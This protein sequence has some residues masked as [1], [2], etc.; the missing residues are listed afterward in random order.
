MI[1]IFISYSNQD[2]DFVDRLAYDLKSI[3]TNIFYAKWE[4][5]VG[6]SIVEKINE[7]LLSHDH[8]IIILSSNSVKSNWVKKEL[9][10]SLMRQLEEN[11]IK[12]KPILIEN[13]DMPPLLADIKYADFRNDYNLGFKDLIDSFTEDFNLE[14]FILLVEEIGKSKTLNYDQKLLAIILRENSVISNLGLNIL[15]SLSDI[16]KLPV[17]YFEN[18][19]GNDDFIPST[20]DYLIRERFVE[21]KIIESIRYLLLTELGRLFL[22]LF[23]KGV[24]QGLCSPVCSQ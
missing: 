6:D 20:V 19:F 22:D 4:I 10:S 8:L 5:K 21:A 11:E 15:S 3:G 18:K 23:S 17:Y 7:A 1:K 9:N 13:C 2:T 16:D 14:P 24:N 12:I